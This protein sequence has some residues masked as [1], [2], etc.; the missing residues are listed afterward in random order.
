MK[1]AKLD[2][3]QLAK[4]NELEQ[5]IGVTLIAYD[6]SAMPAQGSDGYEANSS[7]TS[8]HTSS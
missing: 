8:N 3:Q 6:S 5:A 1:F 2:Q 4:I 7:S